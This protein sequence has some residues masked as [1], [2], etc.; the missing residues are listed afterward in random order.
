MLLAA[1][2]TII[3]II[4][5]IINLITGHQLGTPIEVM[6]AITRASEFR[7]ATLT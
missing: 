6:Q 7:R 3:F 5:Y 1:T 4:R 2:I